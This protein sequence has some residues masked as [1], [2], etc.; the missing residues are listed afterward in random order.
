MESLIFIRQ[1]FRWLIAGF[2]LAFFGSFGQTYFVSI[3]AGELQNEFSLSH[4][5]WGGIY[6]IGTLISAFTMFFVGGLTDIFRARTLS[7]I[8]MVCLALACLLMSAISSAFLLVFAVFALR[9]FGQGLSSHIA[10]VSM[11]RWFVATRGRA[12]AFAALGF[13]FGQAILPLSFVAIS[14]AI[15]WRQSWMVAAGI[16]LLAAPLLYVLLIRER[17]PQAVAKEN[18]STGMQDRHWTRNQVLKHWLFWLILPA[19]LGPA[20]F[21]T[22]FFFHQV[23]FAEFKGW[24]H[25]Q[26]VALFPLLTGLSVLVT[27]TSGWVIDRFK[28]GRLMQFYV[29]PFA[30]SFVL[31]WYVDSLTGAAIAMSVMAITIGLQSTLSAAFWAEYFGTQY[32]GSIKSMATV[33]MVFGS[34]IGPGLTGWLIDNGVAFVD[35]MLGIAIYLLLATAM[36][37]IGVHKSRGRV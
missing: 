26:F 16:A 31:F 36:T 6:M 14:S 9:L 19:Y 10:M 24:T 25:L 34:A 15:G 1:N 21:G 30:I 33:A 3:Y 8:V 11:A 18:N 12:L 23:H 28:S 17:T 13:A 7:V 35:Q 20:T 32:L 29:F 5:E 4:G 22:S 37:M 27:M 2:L